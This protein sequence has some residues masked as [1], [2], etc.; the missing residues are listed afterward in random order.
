MTEAISDYVR[1]EY[2]TRNEIIG[3]EPEGKQTQRSEVAVC[4]KEVQN[5]VEIEILQG[6]KIQGAQSKDICNCEGAIHPEYEE[7]SGEPYGLQ[8]NGSK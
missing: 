4:A 3:E 2:S 5:R 7:Q 1:R 8:F 6:R